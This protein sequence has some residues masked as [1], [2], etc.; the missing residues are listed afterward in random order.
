[1][2]SMAEIIASLSPVFLKL[3]GSLIT[4][5]NTPR[6]LRHK[7]LLR[8]MH[9]IAAAR[10]ARPGLALVL[11]HGSGSFGHVEA[12]KYDTRNGVH[13]PADWQ[14]FAEVQAAAG[15]LNRLVVEAARAAGLPVVTLPPSASAVCQAGVIQS[16]AL[17]PV[18]TALEHNLIPL[19]FGDVALDTLRGGTIVSTEDV[20]RYLA[21]P[22]RPARI[23]LA[24]LERGVLARWPDGEVLT[25]LTPHTALEQVGGAQATDVTGGMAGK[26]KEMLALAQHWPGT[27]IRI[28]SGE[29]AGLV[30]ATLLGT[31]TP[32]TVI[33]A[34]A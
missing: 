33:R 19:V 28:F 34:G 18:Q 10:A 3:G 23:L 14:G 17:A 13:T 11:G 20:F 31:A 15:L 27:E 5:K 21:G 6:A 8:L 1:M 2:P 12:Q 4:A 24:G 30:H 7:T 25:E 9:E 16:L 29:E 22:L 26:V 32:G